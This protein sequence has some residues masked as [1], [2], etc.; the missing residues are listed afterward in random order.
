MGATTKRE[1]V[2]NR[3]PKAQKDYYENIL[4]FKGIQI[5]DNPFNTESGSCADCENVYVDKEW[6]LT[7]RPRVD[8]LKDFSNKFG[9]ETVIN[10]YNLVEGYLVQTTHVVDSTTVGKFYRVFNKGTIIDHAV[11]VINDDDVTCPIVDVNL[12]EQ[13]DII[14][15]FTGDSYLCIDI[16]DDNATSYVL[17][18]VEGYV[19]TVKVGKSTVSE[20]IDSEDYNIL[21]NKYKESYTYDIVSGVST[22]LPSGTF[23]LDSNAFECINKT[24]LT[25]DVTQPITYLGSFYDGSWLSAENWNSIPSVLHYNKYSTN[26]NGDLIRKK[27]PLM[28]GSSGYTPITYVTGFQ[29]SLNNIDKTFMLVGRSVPNNIYIVYSLNDE[30]EDTDAVAYPHTLYPTIECNLNSLKSIDNGNRLL[31]VNSNFNLTYFKPEETYGTMQNEIIFY[32]GNTTSSKLNIIGTIVN[33]Y[34]NID[35]VLLILKDY[36][37]YYYY[38]TTMSDLENLTYTQISGI[39]TAQITDVADDSHKL[40]NVFV[41]EHSIN[42]SG[43][44]YSYEKHYILIN[45]TLIN[46]V[47]KTVNYLAMNGTEIYP[48]YCEWSTGVCLTPY[49]NYNNV[50]ETYDYLEFDS[51]DDYIGYYVPYNDSYELVT[52]LNKNNLGIVVAVTKSYIYNNNTF[53]YYP[54]ILEDTNKVIICSLKNVDIIPS[55]PYIDVKNINNIY[56]YSKYD[57]AHKRLH[58]I[59]NYNY[60]N[61]IYNTNLILEIKHAKPYS[62]L[63]IIDN[64]AVYNRIKERRELLLNSKLTTRFYNQRWTASGSYIFYT[65]N[66]DPTYFPMTN[67]DTLGDTGYDV[68]GFNLISDTGM[69]AYTKDQLSIITPVSDR[70]DGNYDY[71]F[72]ETKN[73]TGNIAPKGT[74]VTSYSVMPLQI[75]KK[76]VFTIQQTENVVSEANVVT[77]ITDAIQRK[78]LKE[79]EDYDITQTLSVNDLYWT[80]LYVPAGDITHMYVLDNRTG[81]WFYWEIPIKVINVF[82]KNEKVNMI[83][84]DGVIYTFETIDIPN[85]DYSS[86]DQSYVMRLYYDKTKTDKYLI[87]WY[88][89]SQIIP[90]GSINHLKQLIDTTFIL[91]D[92]EDTD[93][94]GLSYHFRCFRKNIYDSDPRDIEGDIQYVRSRTVR[95]LF[96]RINFLQLQ[97]KNRSDDAMGDYARLRL[98]GLGFRYRILGANRP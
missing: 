40:P 65:S 23:H 17:K 2:R 37:D 29:M 46:L 93:N 13:K 31:G 50:I 51:I 21:N 60:N 12:F 39:D 86:T 35:H 26:A 10:V 6:S 70:G 77:P 82:N 44:F 61:S 9:S 36:N 18:A 19:P 88:W 56:W 81:A 80:Y 16:S 63:N 41:I 11:P 30:P 62:L 54:N 59:V 84:D 34:D 89:N 79:C 49:W 42:I 5:S 85:I 24:L 98:V 78:W 22:E 52:E 92:D 57:D 91:D 58:C 72:T 43:A 15:M 38:E 14:Y 25:E 45:N 55:L 3:I 28:Q 20:G 74:I 73:T 8:I 1:P 69:V 47:D 64:S 4:G 96:T 90:L 53:L 76:G 83:S 27:Y 75:D 87:D 66:N 71:A 97:L 68:T 95:S 48:F 94:Y 33:K 32:K 7:T 67:F